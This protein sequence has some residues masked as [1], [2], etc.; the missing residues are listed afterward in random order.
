[1]GISENC[2]FFFLNRTTRPLH[3]MDSNS[4]HKYK[5]AKTSSEFESR[6]TFYTSGIMNDVM[7]MNMTQSWP[8][9]CSSPHAPAADSLFKTFSV[10]TH[11]IQVI[12]LIP[13]LFLSKNMCAWLSR[14]IAGLWLGTTEVFPFKSDTQEPRGKTSL[15]NY[16]PT[17]TAYSEP[18]RRN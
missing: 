2:N 16:L 8:S 12:R 17:Y 9:P 10:Q 4:A 15:S 1:M 11:L 14:D 7:N 3:W 13:R 18:E 6:S 5:H